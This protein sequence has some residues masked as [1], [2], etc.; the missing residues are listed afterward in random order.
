MKNSYKIL[1]LFTVVLCLGIQDV[2]AQS[3]FP[4]K[5]LEKVVRRYVFAK[6]NN[7]EP[8]TEQDVENISSIEGN[9]AEITDLTGLEKCRSLALLSISGNQVTDINAIKDLKGLQSLNLADNQIT[10][11]TAVAGLTNLQYLRNLFSNCS[12]FEQTK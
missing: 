10:D 4:D 1:V 12:K 5:N 8:L 3:I 2:M 6:R 7:E 11:V 9:S